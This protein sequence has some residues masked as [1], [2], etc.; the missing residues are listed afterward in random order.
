MRRGASI[1][2][3]LVLLASVLAPLAQG[4]AAS[5]PACCRIGGQHH[6][7]GMGG[8][9]GFRSLPSKCPYRVVPAVTTG[10]AALAKGPTP[11]SL[12]VPER[13]AAE[14]A[15]SVLIPVAFNDVHKRGP[16]SA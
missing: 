12:F 15:L 2:V 3:L 16:P 4:S 11:A 7:M 8:S 13:Q 6:C 14:P 5:L 1:A 10:V 9:E